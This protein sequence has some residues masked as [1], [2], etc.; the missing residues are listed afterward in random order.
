MGVATAVA[1]SAATS[2]SITA[3]HAAEA[4][5]RAECIA[6]V[7]TYQHAGATLEQIHYYAYCAQ[8]LY[9]EPH[10]S[11]RDIIIM[12]KVALIL[13]FIGAGV[14]GYL[15]RD[16]S[17]GPVEYAFMTAG[18]LLLAEFILAVIVVALAFIFLG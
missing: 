7:P 5:S 14:G 8:K 15:G 11:D 3:Q 1:I 18:L 4:A 6:F 9:P 2:A 13:I 10:D 17:E 16:T 12:L